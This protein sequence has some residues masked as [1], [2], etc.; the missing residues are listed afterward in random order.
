MSLSGYL[1]TVIT[2]L[3]AVAALCGA[4]AATGFLM[5]RP[6]RV[7][8]RDSSR[9]QALN[10]LI[11]LADHIGPL[12]ETYDPAAG[13]GGLPPGSS[14]QVEVMIEQSQS[15]HGLTA[16][17]LE[18]VPA[19]DTHASRPVVVVG[20]G[21]TLDAARA[22]RAGV[23]RTGAVAGPFEDTPHGRL[24]ILC[25]PVLV[26]NQPGRFVLTALYSEAAALAP[27]HPA[28]RIALIA[29]CGLLLACV[30]L[31]LWVPNL[32][33]KAE[34]RQLA[35]QQANVAKR[36]LISYLSH[37]IRDPL[38]AMMGFGYLATSKPKEAGVNLLRMQSAARELTDVVNDALNLAQ[39]DAGTM[40]E[41]DEIELEK[42]LQDATQTATVRA[43]RS[44][45]SLLFTFAKDVPAIMQGQRACVLHA[46][47]LVYMHL[48][49]YT[50]DYTSIQTACSVSRTSAKEVIVS[51]EI[52]VRPLAATTDEAGATVK[53]SAP[54]EDANAAFVYALSLARRLIQRADGRLATQGSL[55]RGFQVSIALPFTRLPQPPQQAQNFTG[56]RVLLVDDNAGRAENTTRLLAE[57]GLNAVVSSNGT[58]ALRVIER[59]HAASTPFDL[60]LIQSRIGPVQGIDLAQD[61][62]RRGFD[63]EVHIL[64]VSS[65]EMKEI[66]IKAQECGIEG[67]VPCPVFPRALRSILYNCLNELKTKVSRSSAKN[68]NRSAP[69]AGRQAYGSVL[70]GRKVLVVDDEPAIREIAA[71]LLVDAGVDVETAAN[72]YD[73]VTA[74][75]R[76]GW[77]FDVVL[78]DVQ[79][80]EMDGFQATAAIRALPDPAK[81][82]MPI[83]ALTAHARLDDEQECLA[84]GMNAYLS[85]PFTMAALIELVDRLAAGR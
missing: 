36:Q 63:L 31:V 33:L 69:A 46:L 82:Q 50:R 2:R 37:E 13:T 73:A 11:Y 83:V 79:M 24:A 59:S 67:F 55:L 54:G 17:R 38:N 18:F 57:M 65:L 30:C 10:A 60:V 20:G 51:L 75:E 23:L 85:K 78:M 16:A 43:I 8:L 56:Q 26:R 53:Q 70:R 6:I 74:F 44:N 7:I 61:L 58:D 64:L 81:S 68:A 47:K 12:I 15:L 29:G 21:V 4:F 45:T 35:A 14:E 25:A 48:V 84:A 77:S 49:K 22:V 9:Q 27:F 19:S 76:S 72:G 5:A 41:P 62:H 80:P 39:T 34:A 28:V 66:A 42:L 71:D 3:L 40:P 32:W 52:T 1:R